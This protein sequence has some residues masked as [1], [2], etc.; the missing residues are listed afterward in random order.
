[1]GITAFPPFLDEAVHVRYVQA[2][3]QYSPFVYASEGRLFA[4]WWYML[5]QPHLA[6]SLW[7]IRVTTLL[8]VLPGFSA[9][10]AIGRV[11]AGRWGYALAGLFY[12]FSTYH[13]FFDRLGLADPIAA[14]A[15]S[16]ALYLGYRVSRTA[17]TWDAVLLGVVLFI[18]I[19]IKVSVLPYAIIPLAAGLTLNGR[20]HSWRGK[21]RWTGAALAT[22]GILVGGF[23]LLMRLLHHDLFSLIG[24]HNQTSGFNLADKWSHVVD[25]VNLFAAYVGPI[26]FALL[27]LSVLALVVRRRFYLVISLAVPLV[28]LWLNRTQYSRFFIPAGTILLLCGAVTLA[29]FLRN[30]GKLAQR[31][32]IGA[33]LAYAV[34][35]WLPFA[36]AALYDPVELPVAP[37]DRQ[38]YIRS[39]AGGFGL[40]EAQSALQ[41]YGAREVIGLLSNCANLEFMI[42]D[43]MHVTCP[44]LSPD[45]S[46]VSSLAQLLATNRRPGVYV[47]LEDNP[48]I[49]KTAPGQV[50]TVIQRP[51]GGPHLSI[52]SLAP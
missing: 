24:V 39:D 46:S 51:D 6:A 4:L 40:A 33:V 32:G 8:A 13:L 41:N 42:H 26:G 1:V 23:A 49:P 48:Y 30:Q 5:F 9:C 16:V 14:S 45:G 22:E 7:L 29:N 37:A 12:M 10:M 44:H 2:G 25:T 15:I 35:L 31:L 38:E 34:A 28:V 43:E 50:L 21:L 36:R 19:N 3:F 52:V 18:G 27:L 11:T 20:E 47:V 17:R